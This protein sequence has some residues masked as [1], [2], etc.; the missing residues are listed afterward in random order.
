MRTLLAAA[1]GALIMGASLTLA[2]MPEPAPPKPTAPQSDLT[3]LFIP[4][5]HRDSGL[6]CLP[7]MDEFHIGGC[8]M[9]IL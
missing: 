5:P 4:P 7:W 3:Q 1:F 8:P 9:V 2:R 6:V